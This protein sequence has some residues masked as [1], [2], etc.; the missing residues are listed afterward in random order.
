MGPYSIPTV[1]FDSEKAY[2]DLPYTILDPKNTKHN[3]KALSD[4]K[5][6]TGQLPANVQVYDP[7]RILLQE[8]VVE[9]VTRVQL[10]DDKAIPPTVNSLIQSV[11]PEKLAALKAH[12]EGLYERSYS[13]M[14]ESIQK[15]SAAD[16]SPL[17]K[18]SLEQAQGEI[19]KSIVQNPKIAEAYSPHELEDLTA[20]RAAGI[21]HDNIARSEARKLA[22]EHLD[23]QFKESKLAPLTTHARGEERVAMINGGQASGK[24]SN[25]HDVTNKIAADSGLGTSDRI[26]VSA[27]SFKPILA[28]P[29]HTTG[30]TKYVQSQLLQ[31]EVALVKGRVWQE[32]NA[33]ERK[34][35]II[36]D[37]VYPAPNELALG[38]RSN[39]PM[40][41]IVVARDV[42]PA[43][44]SSFS[45]GNAEGRYEHT[46]GIL[47]VHK[48]VSQNLPAVIAE[49]KGKNINFEMYDNNASPGPDGKWPKPK[50]I[51]S[52]NLKE[53]TLVVHDQEAA[54][55]FFAKKDINPAAKSE[56]EV[57]PNGKSTSLDFLREIAIKNPEMKITVMNKDGHPEPYVP[58]HLE[59]IPTMK[60]PPP[61]PPPLSR[62]GNIVAKGSAAGMGALNIAAGVAALPEHVQQIRNGEIVKG[63]AGATL[64][65]ANI[66][67]GVIS[68]TEAVA[69]GMLRRGVVA[70]AEKTA[71]PLMAAQGVYE[72]ATAPDGKKG[73]AAGKFALSTGAAVAT[74]ALVTESAIGVS[75]AAAG[76]ALAA[77]EGITLAGG[78]A[79]G[80]TI[81]LPA[82][83][84]LGVGWAFQKDLAITDLQR[85]HTNDMA[86]IRP[87]VQGYKHLQA[88][89]D[90]L[91][92]SARTAKFGEGLAKGADGKI[93]VNNPENLDKIKQGLS[94]EDRKQ[95]DALT[96]DAQSSALQ[97]I[98][99]TI[100]QA[101]ASTAS[102]MGGKH[103]VHSPDGKVDLTNEANMKLLRNAVAR[104]REETQKAA[105]QTDQISAF[106]GF[107]KDETKL[108]AHI[109]LESKGKNLDM[110][111]SE[112][113][114]IEL[115]KHKSITTQKSP[116]QMRMDVA[117]AY[118]NGTEVVRYKYTV[119]GNTLIP[120]DDRQPPLSDYVKEMY[121]V[122]PDTNKLVNQALYGSD[123]KIQKVIRWEI[124]DPNAISREAAPKPSPASTPRN[125]AVEAQAPPPL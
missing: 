81:A 35:N 64:A 5:I 33:S 65:G 125:R 112:L 106:P 54:A 57:F 69:P 18:V 114:Q 42:E 19:R 117:M 75:A 27:D 89:A 25:V 58:P 96:K 4:I 85:N 115:N 108:R 109:A 68:T 50:L 98:A 41:L 1:N 17:E 10:A 83:A 40:Q 71:I 111:M 93:D 47:N 97:N 6:V 52:G 36:I 59:P 45:R 105:T 43:L 99:H 88:V 21:V 94:P 113:N 14:L 61:A 124:D 104:E 70:A 107:T 92:K 13:H 20:K 84:A 86:S 34:P 8:I 95:I 123:G 16:L 90:D 62:S 22:H 24:G 37:Q 23:T 60:V 32:I 72:I 122:D 11:P 51:M 29:E 91:D 101:S 31:P 12:T 79:I 74:T 48:S 39:H 30:D 15:N 103:L 67:T 2:Q 116:D 76:T 26:L 53:G 87:D 49:N 66:T 78:T 120:S 80:A 38:T 77:G 55:K 110:A 119:R 102:L 82:V 7:E 9:T 100:D 56:V 118:A 73:E 3:P 121:R 28:G 44:Q 46:S 63:G